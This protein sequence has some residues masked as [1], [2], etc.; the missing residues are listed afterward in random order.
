[1]YITISQPGYVSVNFVTPLQVE[2]S[3]GS[4]LAAFSCSSGDI[5]TLNAIDEESLPQEGK[6]EGVDFPD[7]LF[8]FTINDVTPG[9]TVTVF[10]E[11]PTP[12]QI[13]SKYWK[14]QSGEAPQWFCLNIGSDDG[15]GLIYFEVTDGGI[16]DSDGLA[17]GKIVDPGG[18]GFVSSVDTLPWEILIIIAAVFTAIIVAIGF[19]FWKRRT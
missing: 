8:S 13:G 15:D 18:S 10:M 12:V 5:E 2:T 3:T 1:V 4:G 9:E 19:F 17:D 6:P 11:L 7:G 14:C 16:G